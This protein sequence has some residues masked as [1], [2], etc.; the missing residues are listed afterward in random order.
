[1]DGP[2]FDDGTEVTRVVTI[3]AADVNEKPTVVLV[4]D[5]ATEMMMVF[6]NHDVVAVVDD[7]TTTEDETAP[8]I[9]IAT[10]DAERRGR[11]RRQLGWRRVGGQREPGEWLSLGGDDAG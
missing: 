10:Y 7:G 9:V 4:P 8:A 5:D 3:T 2:E 1:M 6:E 11:Q